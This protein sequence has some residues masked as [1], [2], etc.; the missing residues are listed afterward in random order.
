MEEKK[1]G[2]RERRKRECNK[3]GMG[4][5]SGE[6]GVV[7]RRREKEEREGEKELC[8]RWECEEEKIRSEKKERGM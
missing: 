8:Q 4:G 3:M 5:G 1:I 6:E 2:A 7:L